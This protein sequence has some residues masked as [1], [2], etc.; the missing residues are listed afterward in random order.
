MPTAKT[1]ALSL[2]VLPLT[3]VSAPAPS[4]AVPPSASYAQPA[5][6]P[7]GS[8]IA[9]ASGGDLW[10][11]P[12]AGGTA[13]LLVAH[14]ATESRPV[15]S[16]DG[17]QLAFVST[18]TGNGD[19]YVVS[20]AGG[21]VRRLTWDDAEEVV[22][23][24]SA[25]GRWLYFSSGRQEIAGMND[26]FRVSALG[27]TPLPVTADPYTNE[28]FAAVSRDGRS[29]AFTAQGIVA[30]QWWRHGHSH[31]DE[32]EIWLRQDGARKEDA[33][34]Y[35]K[36]SAGDSKEVWPLWGEDG[37][38]A[39]LYFVSDRGGVEN[40]WWI[41]PAQPQPAAQPLSRFD[42]GRVLWPSISA[43][44]RAIVFE[45]GF[46]IWKIDTATG[47][48]GEVPVSLQGAPV[49]AAVE[50]L[51]LSRGFDELALSPDGEKVAFI[52]R[53]EVFAASAEDGG[54]AA[55]VTE[56][57]D[58]ES[59]LIW[60]PDSRRLVYVSE[61]EGDRQIWMYDFA[62]GKEERLT[63]GHH[64]DHTPRLSPDG[65]RLAYQRGSEGIR[66][67]DLATRADRPVAAAPMI[68]P[69]V[70]LA[71][72]FVWSPDGQWIAFLSS[73][74]RMF[75]NASVVPAAGGEARPV[76][77]L[78]NVGS[79]AISWSPDGRFLL[80]TTGQ[81]TEPGQLARVDLVPRV[82]PFREDQFRS[83]FEQESP[84]VVNPAQPS[85]EREKTTDKDQKDGKDGKDEK[86]DAMK[87]APAGPVE[88][89]FEGIQR[90][91]SLLPVG[92]DAEYQVISPDGKQT[93]IVATV[94]GQT[95]LWLYSLDDE[96]EEPPVAAQ[97][98]STSGE[99]GY[100]QFSPDGKKVFYLDGGQVHWIDIEEGEPT[101]LDVTAEMDVD[102]AREKV[103]VFE[104]AWR[105]LRDNFVDPGMRG[106]DWEAARAEYLP[107]A[108]GSRTPD[109]LRRVVSLM[110]GELN[111]SHS[112]I[113]PPGGSTKTTTGR[114]GL[115]FDRPAYED[116]G[117]LR[118]TEVLPLAP[119]AVS[120]KIQPGD[121]LIAVDGRALDER[122]SLD[123]LLD[124][125][126]GRR[127]VLTLA[128]SAGGKERREVAVQPVDLQTEK[129]LVYRDWVNRRREIVDRLSGG[130]LG[131]VHMFD[132]SASSLE[133]L[134]LDLDAENQGRQGVVVD[135]RHNNGGFVNPYAL[136][137][138]A[139]RGYMGMA[140]RGFDTAPARTVLGQRA[141]E[142]PTILLVN[143]H[144]LSDGE[145]FTEGYRTLGLGKVVGE[146]TAGWI[147]YT[148]N[149]DL[150]DGSNLRLPFIK[151]TDAKGEDMELN[152]RPVD[153][154]V[155]RPVGEGPTGRD[156]QIETAV[157]E[158]L[159]QIG[160]G[161]YSK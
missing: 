74:E 145:D 152:P 148:S 102:F 109:E 15:W 159:R 134:H 123:S 153:I 161:G 122:T 98:T 141:L 43:D 128:S 10:T 135:L 8:E 91:T 49:G 24:W 138:L 53:G 157:R 119:A 118:I 156:V 52:V 42:S 28:Y 143:R 105:W 11:V 88:V 103:A 4:S 76:S 26:I 94:G 36:V 111:A 69:P 70:G 85:E 95:N 34:V 3:L 59:Q 80:F 75:S 40:L 146:P 93:V 63:D 71:R 104:Q 101:P 41:D 154:P 125:K 57:Y 78:A 18:R 84:P 149:V 108:L 130:R 13:R 144:T 67:L 22:D 62:T 106:V 73:R 7:D 19:I 77:F 9:F 96:A 1:L 33:P 97:L 30:A 64:S 6:S 44:G 54:T 12:A 129:V 133:Q 120:R 55:R 137:I 151:I 112:G 100:P 27:G 32:S 99:K 2:L 29:L 61:R 45:R 65:R 126:I 46:R 131:Y 92:I 158:L 117:R 20:L 110:I 38:G 114:L 72:P 127:V 150:V 90:R 86:R 160:A 60:S 132:M 121:W 50:R 82:P 115:R 56:T 140:F 48:T 79:D 31:I 113:R 155:E 87:P 147:I 142:R 139:R 5:I 35:R 37:A 21:D 23:A 16:P 66:V 17:R 39:R 14:P 124:H 89:V 47:Q 81:R 68:A 51:E 83:L 107:R 58:A 136:D 25:D 116:Q